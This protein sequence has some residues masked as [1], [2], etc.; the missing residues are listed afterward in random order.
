VAVAQEADDGCVAS[1]R[2]PIVKCKQGVAESVYLYS[3][4]LTGEGGLLLNDHSRGAAGRNRPLNPRTLMKEKVPVPPLRLQK[5]ITAYFSEELSVRR[6]VQ[7]Q[8]SQ[9]LQYRDRLIANV[10]TGQ[11]DVREMA[12][13]LPDADEPNE[14]AG[15]LE[16]SA[17]SDDELET[18]DEAEA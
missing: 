1:H 17:Q 6:A 10:V 11:M 2:Y 18:M 9:I 5:E 8:I 3:F 13:G 12:A 4:F 7:M 15:N 16:P 14:A